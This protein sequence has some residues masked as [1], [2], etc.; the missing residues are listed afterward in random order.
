MVWLSTGLLAS[1]AIGAVAFVSLALPTLF[2]P[3]DKN[4]AP[5][6]SEPKD[7]GKQTGKPDERA[8]DRDADT[9]K[10][11]GKPEQA[12]PAAAAGEIKSGM[13]MKDLL[14]KAFLIRSTGLCPPMR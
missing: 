13:K 9:S 11:E 1:I 8:R 6:S 10:E 5:Q 12:P 4:G 14:A 3:A 7:P 2:A